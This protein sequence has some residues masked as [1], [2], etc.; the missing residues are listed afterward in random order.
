MEQPSSKATL[1]PEQ[2][3]IQEEKSGEIDDGSISDNVGSGV[4]LPN[5]PDSL[6]FQTQSNISKGSSD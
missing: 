5:L 3:P 6:V 4:H 1:N 2:T